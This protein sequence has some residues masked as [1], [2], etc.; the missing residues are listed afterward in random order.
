MIKITIAGDFIPQK[1]GIS[2]IIQKN[3]IDKNI[4][5]LWHDS[6]LNIINLECP[7]VT[8]SDAKPICKEGSA[9]KT[10][11]KAVEYLKECGIQMVTLANNHIYDYGMLGMQNTISALQANKISHIGGGANLAEASRYRIVTLNDIKIAILNFCEHEF[12]IASQTKG[13]SNPI[14]PI[15]NYHSIRHAKKEADYAIVIVHGG[16]ED[17]PLPTPYIKEL[18]RFYAAVGADAVVAHHPHCISGFEI[19][20]NTPIFYSLGN[21]FF[22]NESEIQ[23]SWNTGYILQLILDSGKISYKIHPILQCTKEAETSLLDK[24]GQAEINRHLQHLSRIISDDQLLAESHRQWI[25]KH[26]RH[27]LSRFL[28][29]SNKYLRALYR[30]NMFPSFMNKKQK[31]HLLNA[32]QCE[33][34]RQNLI[35]YLTGEINKC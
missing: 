10:D 21:F 3:A 12:S 32:V 13:G 7:V 28:P 11:I 14:N 16:I 9:L 19:Y 31:I 33:S 20:N 23:T 26:K 35:E 6:D 29:Y 27:I 4:L 5:D 22:D 34:H 17:Y 15:Q 2:S 24:T 1:R 18:Y 8:S 25:A 30:R